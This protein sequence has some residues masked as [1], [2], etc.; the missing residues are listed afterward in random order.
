MGM[1]AIQLE[2]RARQRF[3]FNLPVSLALPDDRR[4]SGFTQNLSARGVF[5]CTDL[6]LAAGDSL[7]LTMAMPAEVTLAEAMRVRCQARVLRVSTAGSKVKSFV[8]VQL[9]KY[10]YLPDEN[11]LRALSKSPVI[12]ESCEDES[13]IAVR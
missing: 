7:E 10:E 2:R 1:S 9:E 5:L 13:A 11:D 6:P 3:D 8:A 4:G 12:T